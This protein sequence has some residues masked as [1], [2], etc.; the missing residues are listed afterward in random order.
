MPD[1]V[2]NNER[3]TW[4]IKNEKAKDLIINNDQKDINEYIAQV[5]SRKAIIKTYL[6]V[7]SLVSDRATRLITFLKKEYHLK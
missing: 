7:L 3:I 4:Y 2:N 1:S 6:D 5:K